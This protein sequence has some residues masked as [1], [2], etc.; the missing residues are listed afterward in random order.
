MKYVYVAGPYTGKTHNW[1]SYY[2]IDR[3]IRVAEEMAAR[4]ADLGIGFF[5]PH[6]H[7]EHF[8]VIVP[9]V[10]PDFWYELD[11]HFMKSCDAIL[12]LPNWENSKGSLKEK[13][14]ME[15][16]GRPV[17]Y[18]LNDD[19][20]EW[21]DEKVYVRPSRDALTKAG[22]DWENTGRLPD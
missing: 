1:Q 20:V 18:E 12:M 5:C 7:S 4:L 17:F 16:L 19:L 8:E 22:Y 2:E 14:I 11:I 15:E 9:D 21:A 6:K 3:N 10:G 13:R